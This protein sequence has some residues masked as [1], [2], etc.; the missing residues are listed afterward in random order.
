MGESLLRTLVR[1]MI[2][3][4][5]VS[6]E[7][8]GYIRTAIDRMGER[9]QHDRADIIRRL[10]LKLDP[11][12]TGRVPPSIG[13]P[14]A[15]DWIEFREGLVEALVDLGVDWGVAGGLAVW[16]NSLLPLATPAAPRR[17]PPPAPADAPF[18][19]W[20]FS[21]Q[22]AGE[23]PREPNTALETQII[24]ALRSHFIRNIPLPAELGRLMIDLIDEG[25]YIEIL[26][27]P[28]RGT[29]LYR[30]LDAGDDFIRSL[31]LDPDADIEGEHD[32]RVRIDA[33][34]KGRCSSWTTDPSIASLFAASGD[35]NRGGRW[36]VVLVAQAGDNPG[37]FLDGESFLESLSTFAGEDRPVRDE[38]ECIGVGEILLS[39]VEISLRI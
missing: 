38:S 22:R 14:N 21:P 16:A 31:G 34:R 6:E 25:L 3:E 4:G 27:K 9:L 20:A 28:E 24:R 23:V 29:L 18:Q 11:L 1:G 35:F 17:Q 15:A 30:G 36:A 33:G 37:A 7:T 8:L 39:G 13:D 5:A 10:Q 12:G 19:R 26:R 2:S 32:L